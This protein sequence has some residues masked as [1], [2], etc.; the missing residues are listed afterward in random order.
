MQAGLQWLSGSAALRLLENLRPQLSPCALSPR[1]N[2]SSRKW[3]N[4]VYFYTQ[5]APSKAGSDHC[6]GVRHRW[7]KG[8]NTKHKV[9]Q[10]HTLEAD[11]AWSAF[12]GQKSLLDFFQ[13][14]VIEKS[15]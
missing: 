8:L 2:G 10:S 9:S 3:L 4:S 14:V 13:G 12:Y 5:H 1:K 6:G 11:P 7:G 15:Y